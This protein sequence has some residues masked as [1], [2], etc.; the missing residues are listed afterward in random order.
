HLI[1]SPLQQYY[2]VGTH[3][4]EICIYRMPHT[5]W[6]LEVIDEHGNS[7]VWDDEFG[8]DQAA[9]DEVMRTIRDDGI[10]SLIGE[11]SHGAR[12]SGIESNPLRLAAPLSDEE[13]EELDAFL[14]SDATSD[15]TMLLDH[16][17]GYLTAII[18]GPTS[19]KMSQWYS[20]IWGKREEDAPHF[21]TME[22]AQRIMQMIMRHYNGIIWSLEHDED[23]HEPI[24][25]VFVPEDKC[26]EF[27]DA[28][29][30]AAGFMEGLAL[31]RADWQLLF[32][33]PRGHEWLTPIRLLGAD[34]L[35][36]NELVQV[37]KPAQREELAK[38]IQASVAS[39]YRFWFPYRQAI[40]ELQ[41]AR[42]VSRG[43]PK[44]GRNDPCPCGSGKKF[45]KC[46]GVASTPH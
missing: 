44:I 4:V 31:C 15:E 18:V 6:T 32:D 11:P 3:T 34:D 38:H 36:E 2:T 8:T 35:S 46:C 9:L 27:I 43:H 33:D 45:K 19:L 41:Q 16:L 22:E 37:D 23:S 40:Y 24:F 14:L 25:D 7:T 20:G 12:S 30:W 42:T 39:I 21:E 28:E 5:A 1:H 13:L 29:M 17:D 26:K 10:R